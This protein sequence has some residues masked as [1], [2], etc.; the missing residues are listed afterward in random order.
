MVLSAECS[1]LRTEGF[2]CNLYVLYGGLGIG[3]LKF[4]IQ[5]KFFPAVNFSQF[6][7]IKTLDPDWYS[8]YNAGS[9]SVSHE[10]GSE[11]LG[12]K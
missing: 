5:K 8:A 7:V 12:G 11:T 9:G 6:F 1:L 3:K 2:F 4:L 10:Y